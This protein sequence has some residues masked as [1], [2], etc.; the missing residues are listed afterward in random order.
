MN[1]SYQRRTSTRA[2]RALV[3]ALFPGESLNAT[4]VSLKATGV[5]LNAAEVSLNAAGVSL[6]AAGVSLNAAEA[7]LNA[8]GVSLETAEASLNAAGVSLNAAGAGSLRVERPFHRVADRHDP[9][10]GLGLCLAGLR[11]ADGDP[12]LVDVRP[13]YND[14]ITS[15]QM[16]LQLKLAELTA[17]HK[18]I[19]AV[20]F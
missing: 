3:A 15:T 4:G 11:K 8:A 2:R 9:S 19:L 1:V 18:A 7:S 14:L 16:N 17:A 13:V 10:D 5:S 6:N 20:N 12:E